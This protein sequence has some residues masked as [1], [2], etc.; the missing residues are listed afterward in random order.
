MAIFSS[1]LQEIPESLVP[2]LRATLVGTVLVASILNVDGRLGF[3]TSRAPDCIRRRGTVL[4]ASILY[5]DGRLG[6][7]TGRAPDCIRRRAGWMKK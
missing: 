4:V 5:V 3:D 6:F 2:L 7:D 1:K